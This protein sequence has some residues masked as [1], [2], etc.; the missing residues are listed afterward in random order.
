MEKNSL[1]RACEKRKENKEE[2]EEEEGG[3]RMGRAT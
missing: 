3:V 2:E 1:S